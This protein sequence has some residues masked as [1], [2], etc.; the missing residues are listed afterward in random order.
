MLLYVGFVVSFLPVLTDPSQESQPLKCTSPCSLPDIFDTTRSHVVVCHHRYCMP[1]SLLPRLRLVL[2]YPM[3]W[4][5]IQASHHQCERPVVLMSHQEIIRR[6][7]RIPRYEL[8]RTREPSAR[9]EAAISIA[10][11]LCGKGKKR[12]AIEGLEST[13]VKGHEPGR[14]DTRERY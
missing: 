13:P 4:P 8:V 5:L 2:C 12:E 7:I 9:T 3:R 1:Q 6:R 11:S 14:S 10:T